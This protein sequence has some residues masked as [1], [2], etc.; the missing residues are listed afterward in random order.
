MTIDQKIIEYGGIIDFGAVVSTPW[1]IYCNGELALPQEHRE[2]MLIRSRNRTFQPVK[3]ISARKFKQTKWLVA[4][5]YKVFGITVYKR[6]HKGV[7]YKF[8]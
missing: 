1:A 4:K 3:L 6:Y 5:S 8:I 7:L 2:M